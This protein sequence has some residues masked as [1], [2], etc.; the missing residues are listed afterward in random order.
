MLENEIL[1]TEIRKIFEETQRQ[2][3]FYKI[4]KALE[5]KGITVKKTRFQINEYEVIPRGT[6]YLYKRYNQKFFCSKKNN[7]C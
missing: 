3:W 7:L 2:I 4:T 6:R 5:Q 1:S